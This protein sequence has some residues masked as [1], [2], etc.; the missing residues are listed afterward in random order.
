MQ[1]N[2]N[3][4]VTLNYQLIHENGEIVDKGDQPLTYLHGGYSGIF[5]VVE[6][7]LEGKDVG[8]K[9]ALKLQPADA[10]GDYDAELLRIEP[11]N[12]F[13]ENIEVGM[14]FEGTT[15]EE[16]D[17]MLYTITNMVEDKVIVDGNHPLAGI[18]LVFDCTV[19][20]VRQASDDE[21]SHE[22]AHSASCGHHH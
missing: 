13:P 18:A 14:Q 11:R 7:A 1:I 5:P 4:V 10:F 22:H 8:D 21:I 16:D 2:K 19:A 20:D 6:A 17:Y 15:G 12:A 3:T 9:V